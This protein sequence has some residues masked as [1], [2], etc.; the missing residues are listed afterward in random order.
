MQKVYSAAVQGVEATIV[1]VEVASRMSM[2]SKTI[3]VGLPDTAIRESSER[4]HFALKAANFYGEDGTHVINL[5]PAD[6]KKEGPAFDLPIAIGIALNNMGVSIPALEDFLVAG[7]LSLDGTLRPV[8]GVLALAVAAKQAGKK[9]ILLPVENAAEAS[10]ISDLEVYGASSLKEV[11]DH[12]IQKEPLPRTQANVDLTTPPKYV[13]DFSEVKGQAYAKRSLEIAAAGGHNILMSGS[14]GT[15]KSMLAQRIPTIL[16]PLTEAEAIETTKV[17]SVRGLTNSHSSFIKERP[18]RSPHHTISDAGL[19]GGGSII[20]PGE[21]SL[22][23]NGVL[24]LDEFPEFRRTT[25]EVLRQPLEDGQVTISRASGT[26]NFPSKFMLVA[27][28]N[29]CPCGYRG[30]TKTQCSCHS[31]Q[32]ENYQNRLSGPILD[33]IDIQIS[34][35]RVDYK[36]LRIERVEESSEEIRKRVVKA[37]NIQV[38]RYSKYGEDGLCNAQAT[39]KILS[40]Y[41]KLDE[42]THLILERAM[43]KFGYSGRAYNRILKVARTIA[44]LANKE[45]IEQNHIAEAIQLRSH[46]RHMSASKDQV[47]TPIA[48]YTQSAK[49][50]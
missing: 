2:E 32:L 37:R 9:A 34:V 25:L 39:G 3:I 24:F 18:Y 13:V 33:R 21:V 47:I 12:L 15:G 19:L 14:P 29:P 26:L 44:D 23:N 36:E 10:L 43:D 28:M 48:K 46:D 1:E 30:D 5:A 45:Q 49:A 6:L 4:V 38:A 42:R 31:R 50:V 41:C 7:E 27:A 40:K 35:P 11:W 22:A 16:P 17:F 8:K 20:S